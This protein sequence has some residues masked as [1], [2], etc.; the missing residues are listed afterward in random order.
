VSGGIITTIAGTG[1]SGDYDVELIKTWADQTA[2]TDST[3][4]NAITG[5][6]SA[7]TTPNGDLLSVQ[8]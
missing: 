1:E 3:R 8:R 5:T 7:L 2:T 4:N 6:F